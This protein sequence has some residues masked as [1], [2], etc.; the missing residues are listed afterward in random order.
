LLAEHGQD[1]AVLQNDIV[2]VADSGP[3][4]GN[5]AGGKP[6][7]SMICFNIVCASAKR[8]RALSPTTA[9]SRIAG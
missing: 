6:F 8:L 1:G 7:S 2:I 4:T 3:E 5:G 9:S